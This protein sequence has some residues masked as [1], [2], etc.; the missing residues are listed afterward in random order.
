MDL[1][2]VAEAVFRSYPVVQE[3][4][5]EL[6]IRREAEKMNI[7]IYLRIQRVKSTL[8]ATGILLGIDFY[9]FLSI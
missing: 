4:G 2:S 8:I 1:W 6:S 7:F 3:C 9:W 5:V